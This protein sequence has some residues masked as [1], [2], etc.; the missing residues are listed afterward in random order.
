[1]YTI[2]SNLFTNTFPGFHQRP[3]G[4]CSNSFLTNLSAA[5]VGNIHNGAKSNTLNG[6]AQLLL[7]LR[8]RIPIFSDIVTNEVHIAIVKAPHTKQPAH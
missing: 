4:A 6:S 3:T 5:W 7:P 8:G 2:N 1:M